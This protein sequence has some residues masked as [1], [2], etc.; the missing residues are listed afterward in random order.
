MSQCVK[1]L[2]FQTAFKAE[3]N[4]KIPCS[5]HS[6]PHSI[7]RVHVPD[8]PPPGFFPPDTAAAGERSMES[9]T[10]KG[11]PTRPVRVLWSCLPPPGGLLTSDTRATG[12]EIAWFLWK[13]RS[14]S[15]PWTPP[16][17]RDSL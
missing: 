11:A 1:H 4:L 8:P 10:A 2:L 3:A 5:H 14:C 9:L 7:E 16:R 15:H 6:V 13:E 17:P 12:F